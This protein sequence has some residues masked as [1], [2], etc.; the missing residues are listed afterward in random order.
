MRIPLRVSAARICLSARTYY[1]AEQFW[2]PGH[3]EAR[4]QRQW[5]PGHWEI[6]HYGRLHGEDD[7]DDDDYR[8]EARRVWIRGHYRDVEVRVWIP[9]HWEG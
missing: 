7:Y 5:I 4:I 1:P 2:V 9:G 6:E 3:Y 8:D